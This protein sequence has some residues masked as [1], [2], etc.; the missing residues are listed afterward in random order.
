MRQTTPI[1]SFLTELAIATSLRPEVRPD[2][3]EVTNQALVSTVSISSEA[4]A[5]TAKSEQSVTKAA[6]VK[7]ILNLHNINLIGVSGKKRSL[8]ALVRL[9]NGRVLRLKIGDRLNGGSVTNIQANTL[10]Y[11]KSGRSIILLMP[12]N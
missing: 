3:I 2:W 6:T 12:S 1:N 7:N 5:P 11:A 4:Q 8:N 10:T 9:K